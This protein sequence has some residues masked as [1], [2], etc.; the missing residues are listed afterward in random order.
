MWSLI[1]GGDMVPIQSIDIDLKSTLQLTPS[2][3]QINEISDW[4]AIWQ[5]NN[6]YDWNSMLNQ[7]N[8]EG[9]SAQELSL[10]IQEIT[11]FLSNENL[12]YWAQAGVKRI[13]FEIRD[14]LYRLLERE[15]AKLADIDSLLVK[16][17]QSDLKQVSLRVKKL[18]RKGEFNPDAPFDNLVIKPFFEADD[19][20]K[21]NVLMATLEYQS[22]QVGGVS[23]VCQSLAFNLKMKGQN[24]DVVTPLYNTHII[25][26]DDHLKFVCSFSHYYQG[27]WNTS[28]LYEL[29]DDSRK[30]RQILIKPDS[31][32]RKINDIGENQAVYQTTPESSFK[33]RS[34][35]FA[36]AIA[37]LAPL[38]VDKNDQAQYQVLHGQSWALANAFSLIKNVYNPLCEEN[39]RQVPLRLVGHI[40]GWG[41]YDQGRDLPSEIFDNVGLKKYI[42]PYFYKNVNMLTQQLIYSDKDVF[43]SEFIKDQALN[44]S[45]GS[46]Q[47][48]AKLK[49]SQNRFSVARNGIDLD[50][51]SPFS[52]EVFKELALPESASSEQFLEIKQ[53]AKSILYEKGLIKD[54]DK[55]LVLYVGRFD[56]KTK[57]VDML[58]A[59]HAIV[60]DE[61][62]QMVV[63]GCH[64]GDKST[65]VYLEQLQKSC[66]DPSEYLSFYDQL[67]DQNKLVDGVDV[68]MGMLIRLASDFTIVPSHKEADGLVPKEAMALGSLIISS[69]VEGL[70]GILKG[71]NENSE[72]ET[73]NAFLYKD[74]QSKEAAQEATRKALQFY[75]EMTDVEK[76]LYMKRLNHMA[77]S[78]DWGQVSMQ[79]QS[80]YQK[81]M[82]KTDTDFK[83]RQEIAKT[84]KLKKI[85]VK[86]EKT[87]LDHFVDYL[88]TLFNQ[89]QEWLREIG[90]LSIA[91]PT[92]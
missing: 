5:A 13:R 40:H 72:N 48:L 51:F 71:F 7:L 8:V 30:V 16:Q 39:G 78:F 9:R 70:A 24:I 75:H 84:Y 79:M 32:N 38:A 23:R 3:V 45:N 57:G 31:R 41:V 65:Y 46:L 19:S 54:P 21:M 88:F 18:Q 60:R 25:D 20:S 35:Y 22:T 89:L 80:V 53:A 36:S 61:G 26:F 86:S 1:N 28:S 33:D 69:G 42:N 59:I 11:S 43:V 83:K 87:L 14:V 50:Q 49:N 17:M 29:K 6:S 62:G 52:N 2:E 64:Q 27:K 73:F 10:L 92:V 77:Q 67:D 91:Q 66:L 68:K 82:R 90:C 55:P 63:M 12:D 44:S 74:H 56:V 85:D 58:P 34:Q 4:Q 47:T 15:G 76:G 81:I 37:C